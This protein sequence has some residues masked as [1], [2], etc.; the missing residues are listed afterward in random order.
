MHLIGGPVSHQKW[1]DLYLSHGEDTWPPYEVR[2]ELTEGCHLRCQHCGISGIRRPGDTTLRHMP[3]DVW[4]AAVSEI[5]ERQWQSVV[6]LSGRGEPL[7]YPNLENSIDAMR[8][9]LPVN[10]IWMETSGHGLVRR[11]LRDPDLVFIEA[12]NSMALLMEAGLSVMIVRRRAGSEMVWDCLD[13]RTSELYQ[14][15]GAVVHR[16]LPGGRHD[17]DFSNRRKISLRHV[18][19]APDNERSPR[20][21][22]PAWSHT[23]AGAE[24]SI[25]PGVLHVCKLPHHEMSVRWDGRVQLC[26]EDWR[27]ELCL[28]DT[29]RQSLYDVWYGPVARAVRSRASHGYR[30]LRPCNTCDRRA[31]RVQVPELRIPPTEEDRAT[32]EEALR[33]GRMTKRVVRPW[34]R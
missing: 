16:G 22:S 12:A 30:G 1:V 18:W 26:Q 13:E 19:L 21:H 24:P 6:V 20:S 3:R 15:T 5:Q 8:R 14:H 9:L 4:L 29:T 23:G 2:L 7:L 10:S 11:G 33:A 34:E 32:V 17:P 25:E 28:G 31:G 27:G